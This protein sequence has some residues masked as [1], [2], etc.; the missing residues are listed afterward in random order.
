MAFAGLFKPKVE[1]WW[2]DFFNS[3]DDITLEAVE[4]EEQNLRASITQLNIARQTCLLVIF[5]SSAINIEVAGY[6]F[7]LLMKMDN[8][9]N[10]VLI[11]YLNAADPKTGKSIF[12]LAIESGQKDI[13]DIMFETERI[14]ERINLA[15]KDV[16]GN[17]PLHLAVLSDNY[18]ELV[19]FILYKVRSV[20]EIMVHNRMGNSA[21]HVV[22]MSCRL[23]LVPHFTRAFLTLTPQHPSR[24]RHLAR[25]LKQFLQDRGE[26]GATPL[27]ILCSTN[28]A[29]LPIAADAF[30][31]LGFKELDLSYDESEEMTWLDYFLRMRVNVNVLSGNNSTPLMFALFNQHEELAVHLMT[32]KQARICIENKD[33]DTPLQLAVDHILPLSAGTKT[34]SNVSGKAAAGAESFLLIMLG[35]VYKRERRHA[36]LPLFLDKISTSIS[37]QGNSY[38]K[39]FFE[40]I[41]EYITSIEDETEMF[42]F[43]LTR[44][45]PSPIKFCN[46]L[47]KIPPVQAG[48]DG[49]LNR[50][51]AII[52]DRINGPDD[53]LAW[54]EDQYK[55]FYA[56][57]T[58]IL[59]F[60]VRAKLFVMRA[61]AQFPM[62][63][64][65]LYEL[66]VK[67][68]RAINEVFGCDCCDDTL[69]V[70]RLLLPSDNPLIKG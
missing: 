32:V 1:P 40:F 29:L 42:G 68:D 23:E 22:F 28:T 43:E 64:R 48:G 4:K 49:R 60:F 58:S 30:P 24:K 56:K 26:K 63:S 65:D 34:N 62:E 39:R 54:H 12:H 36:D 46:W 66:E 13:I 47:V 9:G 8:I 33:A 10:S 20:S 21:F 31:H 6:V 61:G 57:Q 53:L 3:A 7:R 17:T 38:T 14:K 70:L 37:T 55:S 35:E 27:H 45:L 19:P 11:N 16:Y 51:Q 41:L 15:V 5:A 50:I 52:H 67:F 18:L 59:R 69:N 44:L 25:Q 2:Q